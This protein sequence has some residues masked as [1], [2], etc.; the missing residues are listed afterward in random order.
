[1][2]ARIETRG[3]RQL[4]MRALP[5]LVI[6]LARAELGAGRKHVTLMQ[7][8]TNSP[9]GVTALLEFVLATSAGVAAADF[10]VT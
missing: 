1:M 4:G 2:P 7:P 8:A 6:V 9:G 10:V 5:A 3:E